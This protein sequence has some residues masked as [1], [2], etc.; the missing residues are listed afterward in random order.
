MAERD[1]TPHIRTVTALRGF[2]QKVFDGVE[3][4]GTA[5]SEPPAAGC[6]KVRRSDNDETQTVGWDPFVP[7]SVIKRPLNPAMYAADRHALWLVE[8]RCWA[9]V[10][11]L[12]VLNN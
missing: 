8:V 7:A 5:S 1:P 4:A 11:Q 9:L 6:V 10:L 3:I 12:A 2:I